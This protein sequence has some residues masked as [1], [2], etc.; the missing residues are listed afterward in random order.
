MMAFGRMPQR[1]IAMSTQIFREC[2]HWRLGWRGTSLRV[3]SSR[4]V[5]CSRAKFGS[6][7]STQR[8]ESLLITILWQGSMHCFITIIGRRCCNASFW[9]WQRTWIRRRC[10]LLK[11][12]MF[13]GQQR[14]ILCAGSTIGNSTWWILASQ[15]VGPMGRWRSPTSSFISSL[16]LTKLAYHWMAPKDKGEV[17]RRWWCMILGCPIMGW[18]PGGLFRLLKPN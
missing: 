1:F 13:S 16:T 11:I 9:L 3:R 18:R 7:R 12:V 4:F 5:S 15:Q 17:A 2:L 8:R 6:C 10:T 14:R